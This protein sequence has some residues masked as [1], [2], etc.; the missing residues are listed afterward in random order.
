MCIPASVSTALKEQAQDWPD[1]YNSLTTRNNTNTDVDITP[2]AQAPPPSAWLA[3]GFVCVCVACVLCVLLFLCVASVPGLLTSN[4]NGID[5]VVAAQLN[6]SRSVVLPNSVAIDPY[7]QHR[8]NKHTDDS[9][10]GTDKTIGFFRTC[11]GHT[12]P[13]TTCASMF[14]SFA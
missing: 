10:R 4:N 6:Q 7:V 12:H 14:L 8:H 5:A 2:P 9:V 1:F 11:M 13:A 3:A